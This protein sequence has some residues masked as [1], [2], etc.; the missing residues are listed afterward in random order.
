MDDEAW[1]KRLLDEIDLAE[2]D[3]KQRPGANDRSKF[4]VFWH[5]FMLGMIAASTKTVREELRQRHQA[6]DARLT[7]VEEH[8]TAQRKG[9]E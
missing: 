5:C 3:A 1:N 9:S 8:L 7:A 2:E 6:M 4:T